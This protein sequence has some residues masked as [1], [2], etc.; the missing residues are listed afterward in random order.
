MEWILY[1]DLYSQVLWYSLSIH[2]RSHW[3]WLS[4][5]QTV[6]PL[7]FF[8]ATLT[9]QATFTPA[10][11]S[12][13]MDGAHSPSLLICLCLYSH[14]SGFKVTSEM[15]FL[16]TLWIAC[17]L[18][19]EVTLFYLVAAAFCRKHCSCLEEAL[20]ITGWLSTWVC[21]LQWKDDALSP[22]TLQST[23]ANNPGIALLLG[24]S[25]HLDFPHTLRT[26][27]ALF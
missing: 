22:G 4:P 12:L 16:N 23:W 10:P 11:S 24:D 21:F 9:C 5:N 8:F 19:F 6:P 27:W 14:I 20:E 25:L 7:A 13:R 26:V 1:L 2:D 3:L 15:A 18:P 17:F